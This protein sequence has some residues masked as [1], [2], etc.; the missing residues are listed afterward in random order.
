MNFTEWISLTP[1][2]RELERHSWHVFEPG[3]WHSIAYQAAA[4]FAREFASRPQVKRIFKSL[5]HGE[6][7]IVAVQTEL[8][9]APVANLPESYA[10]FRV[11][12]FAGRTPDGVLV[13]VHPATESLTIAPSSAPSSP[14]PAL[15]E[16]EYEVLTP[17]GEIDFNVSLRLSSELEEL[18][19]NKPK[20]LVVDLSRVSYIDS[21]GLSVLVKG[22][23]KVQ[24]Y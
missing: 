12:Q 9:P 3:Y 13:D 2:E 8:S 23:Q 1:A 19:R 7:L 5:Y 17:E 20:K 21:S 24:S 6:E 14:G 10:G 15:G 22:V 11:L 4:H 16:K 18:I